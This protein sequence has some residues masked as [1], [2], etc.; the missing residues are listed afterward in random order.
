MVASAPTLPNLP[1]P[2]QARLRAFL[3][4]GQTLY[5]HAGCSA[6]PIEFLAWAKLL[7]PKPV[8]DRL[9]RELKRRR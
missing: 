2:D 6:D 4:S 9:A 1:E 3:A 5:Q 7:N 8:C